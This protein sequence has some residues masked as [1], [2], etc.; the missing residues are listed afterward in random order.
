[1]TLE[2]RFEG[3]MWEIYHTAKSDCNYNATRFSQMLT[4]HGGVETANRLLDAPDVSDGFTELWAISADMCAAQNRSR[5]AIR[6]YLTWHK[7][8]PCG[9]VRGGTYVNMVQVGFP[10]EIQNYLMG[11]AGIL[12]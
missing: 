12:E 3:A 10:G 11:L 5:A 8:A 9:S 6:R 2:Q 4:N 7:M 1:M